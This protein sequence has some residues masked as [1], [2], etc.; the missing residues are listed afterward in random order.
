MLMNTKVVM[1]GCAVL[2]GLIGV[3]LSFLPQEAASLLGWPDTQP[4]LLQLL[5][6]LYFS[7]A[8]MNW[9]AKANL[10]GGIYGKPIAL[11]NFTHFVIGAL[12][13]IKLVMHHT[14]SIIWLVITALYSIFAI[15]FG[16]ILFTHPKAHSKEKTVTN[17]GES[18]H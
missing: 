15:L 14:P 12:A 9:T 11:G 6:A 13:L 7:V 16:Y 5:G 10:I 2:L 8:M 1:T 4:I 18:A 17:V 3:V